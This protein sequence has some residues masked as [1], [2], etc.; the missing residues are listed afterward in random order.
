MK[1][2]E[3]NN[4]VEVFNVEMEESKEFIVNKL[5]KEI[6]RK[7][8]KLKNNKLV[9]EENFFE[10]A[11]I[12]KMQSFSR[13]MIFFCLLFSITF[14]LL[15]IS[16]IL[17][18][19]AWLIAFFILDYLV[20]LFLQLA[21][22]PSPRNFKSKLEFGAM[23]NK[24]LE[25]E[26]RIGLCQ[27]S[28][29]KV[30]NA[31]SYPGKYNTDI[32]GK[33]NIPKSI[34]YAKIGKV[35]YYTE[36]DYY[37]FEDKYMSLFGNYNYR[38]FLSFNNTRLNEFHDIYSL[39]YNTNSSSINLIIRICYFLLLQ[40]IYAMIYAASPEKCVTIYP[41]K[42]ITQE[43]AL[44]SHT[45]INVHGNIFKPEQYKIIEIKKQELFEKKYNKHLE[46][47]NKKKEEREKEYKI[48]EEKKKK[49]RMEE[50]EERIRREQRQKEIKENTKTLSYFYNN[51]Y[52]IK[53]Y[54]VYNT[55][56]LDLYVEQDEDDFHFERTLGNYDSS[57][58][59]KIEDQGNSTLYYPNGYDIKIQVFYFERKFT[60]K[61]GTEFTRSFYIN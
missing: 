58:V 34:H 59:E 14:Y 38:L 7:Y 50:E 24:I 57:C 21:I 46:I 11:K 26:A 27:K 36:K 4:F 42:L 48:E 40:P 10:S 29:D 53:V 49:K 41:A 30:L 3:D 47:E 52:S 19:K 43:F 56:H 1:E 25:S 28:K 2:N 8:F 45:C 18:H 32:T 51:N 39:K 33:I 44:N 55:V 54:K 35:Q 22:V 23:L 60:I 15:L 9:S 37:T 13:L 31:F 12:S 5:P 20:A 6:S 17:T 61:I 16:V